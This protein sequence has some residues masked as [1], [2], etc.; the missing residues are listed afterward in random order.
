MGDHVPTD[1]RS[2][3]Y[4]RC[5]ASPSVTSLPEILCICIDV[6]N[7][8]YEN[9]AVYYVVTSQIGRRSSEVIWCKESSIESRVMKTKKAESDNVTYIFLAARWKFEIKMGWAWRKVKVKAQSEISEHVVGL[10]FILRVTYKLIKSETKIN[11]EYI[12]RRN[13][14]KYRNNLNNVLS[15]VYTLWTTTKSVVTEW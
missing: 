11:I 13:I 7:I 15:N 9:G 8:F 2:S 14:T 4:S 1:V 3:K 6:R 5:C 12:S 10:R